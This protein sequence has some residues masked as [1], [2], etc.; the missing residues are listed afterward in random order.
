MLQ[1]F[2][3][4][5][6]KDP[7]IVPVPSQ[8]HWSPPDQNQYKANFD[9][10]VFKRTNS[11]GLGVIIRDNKGAVI[12]A[13]AMRIPLPQFVATIEALA[14]RHAVQC[15]IKIGLHDVIFEGDAAV[16][17]QAIKHGLANQSLYGHIVGD[18]ID[19]SSLLF[20]SDFCYVNRSCNKVADALAKRASV[21]LDIQVWLEDCLGN[22]APLVLY[23][24]P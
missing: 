21:G 9:G 12:G 3:N 19:Q 11:A 22:I 14:C 13:L 24:V 6:D 15:A 23:D 20:H 2:L 8:L 7:V 10:A 16:V 18:I 4:Y 5:Q 17:I 1:D